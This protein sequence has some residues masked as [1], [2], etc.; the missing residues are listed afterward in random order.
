MPASAAPIG[1][2]SDPV[3]REIDARLDV[4][5][6]AGRANLSERYAEAVEEFERRRKV[7]PEQPAEEVP[8][9]EVA[10]WNDAMHAWHARHPDFGSIGAGMDGTWTAGWGAIAAGGAS[11]GELL[12]AANGPALSNPHALPGVSGAGAAPGLGEGLAV[13]RA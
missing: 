13:L 2:S 7:A 9:D 1:T 12:R 3:Y 11:L 10:R 6:Q 8:G 5:L 4:L